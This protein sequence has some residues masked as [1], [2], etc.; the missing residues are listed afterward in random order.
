MKLFKLLVLGLALLVA[1]RAQDED[2]GEESQESKDAADE[3]DSK[4]PKAPAGP[5]KLAPTVRYLGLHSFLHGGHGSPDKTPKVLLLLDGKE[6]ELPDWYTSVAMSFKEGKKKSVS[7]A[8]VKEDGE[9]AAR[10]FGV[11][12]DEEVPKAGML[13]VAVVDGAGAGRYARFMGTEL[14]AGGG[15]AVRAVKEFVRAAV[16]ENT[17]AK[18]LPLPSFP[19]PDI[20]RKQASTSL[21]ELT[22]DNLPTHCFGG[23]KAICLIALMSDL[24]SKC[25]EAVAELAKRHRNDNVQFAWLKA[26]KQQDFVKG[27]GIEMSQLPMLVAVKVGKRNRFAKLE[28]ELEISS[29]GGFVDRILGGDMT[30]TALKPLPELEPAYLQESDDDEEPAAAASG[31]GDE[32]FDDEDKVEL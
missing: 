13:I 12:K 25:P 1:V 23:A 22:F 31:G 10:R 28:G 32:G 16:D 2:A 7:F 15:A 24:P 29:M 6:A 9:K 8:V 26:L 27:F 21:V 30:F 19:P 14:R 3:K 18:L 11:P 4:A 5:S 20:P 17:E